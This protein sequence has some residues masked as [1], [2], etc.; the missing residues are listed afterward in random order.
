LKDFLRTPESGVF[1]FRASPLKEGTGM[2]TMYISKKEFDMNLKIK[3]IEKGLKERLY[4]NEQ[5][6]FSP[7]RDRK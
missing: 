4:Y 2:K 1:N 7:S 5:H 6:K 3:K